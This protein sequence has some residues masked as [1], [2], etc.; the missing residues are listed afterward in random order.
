MA[1]DTSGLRPANLLSDKERAE[2]A[3]KAGKA[4]GAARRQRR[5]QA[6]IIR[7]ILDLPE[8]DPARRDEL[9]ALG[10]PG[11]VA[12]QINR[13]VAGRAQSG[14]VEAARYLRDTIGERPADNVAVDLTA[15]VAS[16][17][18][19]KLTDAQLAELASRAD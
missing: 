4:S 13:A 2:L 6:D 9:I 11:T 14:D 3:S 12:D 1:H 19:S 15:D 5:K 16:I 17:D 7:A 10:L 18:M 8:T